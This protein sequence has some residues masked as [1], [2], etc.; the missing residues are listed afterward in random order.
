MRAVISCILLFLALPTVGGDIF[1][2][3]ELASYA[4]GKEFL[5]KIVDIQRMPTWPLDAA[6]PPFSA[7][8]A[9]M[10]ARKQMDK[11]VSD[12]KEWP[13]ERIC[14]QD[15]GDNLHWIYVVEFGLPPSKSGG[16]HR[17]IEVTFRIVVLM[18]GTVIKPVVT[19]HPL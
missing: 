17:T 12:G 2:S 19:S 9:Q 14:L 13:L 15:M 8:K 6:Y 11:L 18:D 10:L 7:R 4:E 16:L 3:H 1:K 5:F